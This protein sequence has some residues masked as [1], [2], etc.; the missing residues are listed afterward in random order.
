MQDNGWSKVGTQGRHRHVPSQ[1]SK[2]GTPKSTPGH[3]PHQSTRAPKAELANNMPCDCQISLVALPAT[4]LASI[5]HHLDSVAG[6]RLAQTCHMCA[7]EFAQQ[8]RDFTRKA[9]KE[10]APTVTRDPPD[11]DNRGGSSYGTTGNPVSMHVKWEQNPGSALRRL[12]AISQQADYVNLVN[13]LWR[14]TWSKTLWSDLVCDGM[15]EVWPVPVNEHHNWGEW[16]LLPYIKI[17]IQIASDEHLRLPWNWLALMLLYAPAAGLRHC[18]FADAP[19]L[20]EELGSCCADSVHIHISLRRP[21]QADKFQLI[22]YK[23]LKDS[24]DFWSGNEDAD[25]TCSVDSLYG[26]AYP[27]SNTVHVKPSSMQKVAITGSW[28]KMLPDALWSLWKAHHR[29]HA[30]GMTVGDNIAVDLRDVYIADDSEQLFEYCAHWDLAFPPINVNNEFKP[31]ACEVVGQ[32]NWNLKRQQAK[33]RS[34]VKKVKAVGQKSKAG[35][36]RS[37]QPSLTCQDVDFVIS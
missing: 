4:A 27:N 19:Q 17:E 2:R 18:L 1:P 15:P 31:F 12:C 7:T 35:K 22:M 13:E 26:Y 10:L 36:S 34:Q 11:F 5:F 33:Q 30:R 29:Y 16:Q 32:S 25:D 24:S 37:S 9:C 8:R 23:T 20:P 6:F 14:Q 3:N 21:A 28:C